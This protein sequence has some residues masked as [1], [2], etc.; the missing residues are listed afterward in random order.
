MAYIK[1]NHGAHRFIHKFESAATDFP[2]SFPGGLS[3]S[4]ECVVSI[5]SATEF[6]VTIRL[7]FDQVADINDGSAEYFDWK[8][9]ADT[10]NN[11]LKVIELPEHGPTGVEFTF[12]SGS[13]TIW[14]A[15]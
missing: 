1:F 5:Q 2:N 12:T 8:T 14:I 7:T 11:D 13:P 4:D 9:V 10:D 15:V 3:I 6:Q